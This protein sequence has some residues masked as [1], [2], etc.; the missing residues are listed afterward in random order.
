MR[1]LAFFS[2]F[3]LLTNVVYSRDKYVYPTYVYKGYIEINPGHKVPM[4]L[5]IL[6]N[7]DSSVN[8]LYYYKAENGSLSLSGKINSDNT[9]NLIERT[10]AGK[11]TGT[12]AG[13]IAGD[14]NIISGSWTSADNRAYPFIAKHEA[15]HSY[16]GYVRKLEFIDK[17]EDLKFAIKNAS[18]VKKLYI[19]DKGIKSLPPE[20]SKIKNA[21]S[22]CLMADNFNKFPVAL[23]RLSNVE[24]ISLASNQL[25]EITPQI[26]RLQSLRLLYIDFN[27]LT[28][29][30]KEIGSLH[31]LLYLDLSTN[32]LNT[33]PDEIKDLYQLQELHLENNPINAAEQQRIRKLLPNCTIYF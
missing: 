15:N 2:F 21:I 4:T 25:K 20:F 17:Y 26:N 9:I 18:K 6:L 30:P 31:N 27:K 28:K 29:L 16:W 19:Y 1:I 14:R 23:T 32:K 33:V 3:I 12:F 24:E 10:N 7:K 13:W 11:I 22:V 5:N 8:G